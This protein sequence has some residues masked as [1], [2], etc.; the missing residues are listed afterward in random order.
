MENYF[1]P[2]SELVEQPRGGGGI[3]G[4]LNQQTKKRQKRR[5]SNKHDN[6]ERSAHTHEL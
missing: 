4:A 1:F 3:F 6:L 5:G 2:R